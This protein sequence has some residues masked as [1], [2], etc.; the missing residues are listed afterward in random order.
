M[1]DTTWFATHRYPLWIADWRGNS[2]PEVPAGNWGGNGWKFWQWT[3]TGHVSGIVPYVDRDRFNGTSLLRGKIASLEVTPAAGGAISGARISCGGAATRCTRLANPDTVVTLAAVPDPGAS[4]LGW[5]GAC[6]SAG[7]SPTCDVHVLG[8]KQVSAVFGYPVHVER[9]G[10]G[11]GAVSSSPAG[12][13]CGATTTTCTATFAAGST[14]T[15]TA[16]PD[17]ASVFAGW[18][19]R[20]TGG[21]ATCAFPVSSPIDVVAAFQSVVS[22][23]QAGSGTGFAWGRA[24]HAKAIGGSYR[25]ERRAGASA[26]YPFSGG[27]VTL[28]TVSGPAMGKGRIQID[29]AT[30]ETFDGYRS[31]LATSVNHRF[32]GLGPGPH[33]L[34]V[35]V[36]GTKRPAAGGTRVAVDAVRW[37]GQT[38]RNPA[39]SSVAWA[40]VS[41][42][43]ASAGT[44]TISDARDALA[45]LRFTGSGVSLRTLRSPRMGK[46]QVWLD[47]EV[48]KIVDLYAPAAAFATVPLASGLTDGPHTVRVVVLGTRRT[49]SRG[50]A[51]VVDR[52]L[53]S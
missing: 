23:E 48:V 41:N 8:A 38:Y 9:E 29:G 27:T 43:S 33:E 46:A 51:V 49:A 22:V 44:Y 25:W 12:I 24:T 28:F 35:R 26:V 37:G 14:V 1:G 15:L 18:S 4:L 17:S 45:R 5:T 21:A 16:E 20:C 30:V 11:G 6:S 34:S 40:T 52:W 36:L 2:A 47:G 31:A 13:D 10:S 53:V 19:G 42:A 3:A 50:N 7:S 39:A 32:V